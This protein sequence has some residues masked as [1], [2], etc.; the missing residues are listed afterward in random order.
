MNH[1]V[2]GLFACGVRPKD[3][4]IVCMAGRPSYLSAVTALDRLGAVPVV[5]PP[6]ATRREL[7]SVIE[8]AGAR[9][10]VADPERARD[11]IS[12]GLE[13]LVLGGGGQ[14]RDLGPGLI[15]MEA[16]DPA[17]VTLPPG[18][19]PD[20]ARAGDPAVIL[21]VRGRGVDIS[22]APITH[23]RWALSAIGAAAA[24]TLRPDDTVYCCLPL[25]HPA[26]LLVSVGSALA[27]GA[28]LA[29]AT[30]F[31]AA[32]FWSD[33]RRYGA[34]VVFYAGEMLRPL[35]DAD[36]TPHDRHHPLRLFAGSGM[37]PD[38]WRRVSERFGA[39]VLEFYASTT[40]NVVLANA[41]GAKVGAIGRPLPGSTDL[42]IVCF[43]LARRAPVR[44][45]KGLA[46]RAPVNDPGLGIARLPRDAP[47]RGPRV[48][49]DVFEP[50]DTWFAAQDLL[51]RDEDGD[52]WF[53]DRVSGMVETPAGFVSTRQI[54][55]ALYR[56]PEIELAACLTNLVAFVVSKG[57]LDAARISRAP[58]ERPRLVHRLATM[59]MTEGFQPNKLAL[60]TAPLQILETLRLEE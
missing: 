7:E 55:D 27:S 51:R 53:V 28:R 24:C 35:V 54:E 43:D 45:K 19:Q 5:V 13:V 29:L 14:A 36:V 10:L 49:H 52:I 8:R 33:V 58:G 25:H 11:A 22:L 50:G 4:V 9:H 15:D 2:K 34:T 21:S 60:E 31:D 18:F 39:G 46:R 6:N 47:D 17:N 40:Q 26:G 20:A 37:R 44:D 3:R 41:S 16:I 32:R 57:P 30:E 56:L 23:H 12:L 48:I 38:L 1:V 59:P 42:E